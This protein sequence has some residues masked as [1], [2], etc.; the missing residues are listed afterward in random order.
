MATIHAAPGPEPG[1]TALPPGAAPWPDD[2]E[3]TAFQLAVVELVSGLAEGELMTYGEVADELGRPG[4]GQA[5][6]NVLRGV[7]DLPWWRVVPAEGRLYRTHAP[8][9]APLLRAEG[10]T[11]D[12]HRRVHPR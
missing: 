5:V 10:H 11:V 8:V 4:A 7:P 2:H 9:Q 3:P 12:E 6:A 1:P